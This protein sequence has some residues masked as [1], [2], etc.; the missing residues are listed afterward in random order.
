MPSYTPAY[1]ESAAL[2]PEVEAGDI[3]AVRDNKAAG[4][5]DKAI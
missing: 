1:S 5:S 4:Q 2:W 3:Q